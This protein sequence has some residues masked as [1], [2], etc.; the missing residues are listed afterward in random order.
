MKKDFPFHY[1]LNPDIVNMSLRVHDHGTPDKD[2]F[3]VEGYLS[4]KVDCSA[5][6]LDTDTGSCESLTTDRVRCEGAADPHGRPCQWNGESCFS[7]ESGRC[8]RETLCYE[9]L[10]G[11][12]DCSS[13][14]DARLSRT[15]SS[16]TLCG[17][18]DKDKKCFASTFNCKAAHGWHNQKGK[19]TTTQMASY[20]EYITE[21][22][23]EVYKMT[24][25]SC[26]TQGVTADVRNWKGVYEASRV[27]EKLLKHHGV[28]G[29]NDPDMLIGSSH[30]A[31]LVL[32]PAQ[33]RAQFSLWAVMS[34]PLMLG[35]NVMKITDFDVDTWPQLRV[36][37]ALW[38]LRSGLDIQAG[39]GRVVFSNCPAYP[40]LETGV[41]LDGSPAFSWRPSL[42]CGGHRYWVNCGNHIA[43][44]CGS[45]GTGDDRCHG[46]C[47][48][49]RNPGGDL[50]K[51]LPVDN[52]SAKTNVSCGGHHA[53]SCEECPRGNGR[54]WCNKD[55]KWLDEG[56]CVPSDK[57][58]SYEDRWNPWTL[59]MINDQAERECQ[60]VWAKTL[61]TGEEKTEN[62]RLAVKNVWS[63]QSRMQSGDLHLSLE[64]K[65]GHQLLLLMDAKVARDLTEQTAK[66]RPCIGASCSNNR[67]EGAFFSPLHGDVVKELLSKS[68]RSVLEKLLERSI[69]EQKAL[70]ME[71]LFQELPAELDEGSNPG[72]EIPT[73]LA[74]VSLAFLV[75]ILCTRRAHNLQE[76]PG[77]TPNIPKMHPDHHYRRTVKMRT[78]DLSAL[79]VQG[80]LEEL[81]LQYT[82]PTYD[83]FRKNCCHFAEDF[84]Q[85]LGVGC[86][87]AWVHRLARLAARIESILE[88]AQRIRSPG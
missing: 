69:T 76:D 35:V 87:P 4:C 42:V 49:I 28:S 24:G 47:K 60:I 20:K 32:T 52:T 45:C 56:E 66:H 80:I 26:G 50:P 85:R 29:W 34:A 84:C 78:T 64:A 39:R 18:K 81:M 15:D 82:G 65:G 44:N 48:W 14:T 55:C 8:S 68:P 38:H 2:F 27:M 23:S 59:E 3:E 11:M 67:K 43:N 21:G 72:Y 19:V 57:P 83:L 5:R 33:S 62:V 51:C 46:A 10:D 74:L 75:I 6:A 31:K 53:K 58:T 54:T 40:D 37:E 22:K 17:W 61:S 12:S 36:K 9:V 73:V 30:G 77:V 88:A 70:Q 16:G 86:I 41:N 7:I 63:G 1:R 25:V 13:R 71:D 79:Q